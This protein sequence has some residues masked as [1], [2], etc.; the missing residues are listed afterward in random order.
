MVRDHEY[1]S[2]H[3]NPSSKQLRVLE[4]VKA[5]G[6]HG[7]TAREWAQME[8]PGGDVSGVNGWGGCFSILHHSGLIAALDK[9]RDSHHAYVMPE[10]VM[11][12]ETWAGYDHKGKTVVIVRHCETCT[13]EEN[14]DE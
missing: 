13:C 4:A 11:G 3:K 6:F 9:R 10:L 14:N 5:A 8:S 1:Q 2:G 7:I 12:R